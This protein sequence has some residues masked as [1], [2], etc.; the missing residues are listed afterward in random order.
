MTRRRHAGRRRVTLDVPGLDEPASGLLISI[1][2]ERRP[3]VNDLFLRRGHWIDANRPDEVLASEKFVAGQ[4]ASRWA[5]R[6]APSS[7]AGCAA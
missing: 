1:E 4:Q 2:A 5:I 3:P 6:S 7:T